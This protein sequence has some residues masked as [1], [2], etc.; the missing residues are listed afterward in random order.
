MN[1]VEGTLVPLNDNV[2]ACDMNFEEQKTASGIVLRSD[3]GKS[4]GVKPRWCKVW[5]VGPKQTDVKVGE[6][7]YVEHARWTRGIT[8]REDGREI[9]IRRIDTTA[10]LLQSDTEPS[11]TYFGADTSTNAPN[12]AYRI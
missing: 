7:I 6:W 5:A 9:V 2:L 12:E 3:N 11:D 10:I 1:V 8:V 4:E